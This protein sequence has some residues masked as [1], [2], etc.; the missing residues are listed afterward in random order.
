MKKINWELIS[1]EIISNVGYAKSNVIIAIQEAKE[2]NFNKALLL[3]DE[4]EEK[5]IIAEQAHMDVIVQEAKGTKHPF[6][7][8]FI[9]AEDQMLTTQMLILIGKEL[10]EIHT[11]L[12]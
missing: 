2:G 7:V 10:I 11:K 5:M 4:A 6:S 12:K 3:I 1:M 9:H 8:L